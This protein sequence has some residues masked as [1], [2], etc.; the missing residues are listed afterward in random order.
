M[1]KLEKKLRMNLQFFS[2]E[3]PKDPDNKDGD[4]KDPDNDP[5][6][7]DNEPDD[8]GGDPDNNSDGKTF[9]QEDIDRIVR[10]RLDRERKKREDAVKKEREEAERKRLEENEE[11]K[12]L[13]DKL[14]EQLDEQKRTALETKKESLLA[15]AG[16]D[17]GQV[18][19][20]KKYLDGESEEELKAALDDLKA[21]IPPKKQY[22]DPSPGNGSKQPPKKTNLEEKGKS[23][24]QRLKAKGKIRGKK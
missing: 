4:T 24:Y 10:E 18:Q 1:K 15:T 22:G 11:Y 16:Y 20:Y 3:D 17:E 8:T 5:K 19:R 6:D 12:E 14:Q 7:P 9:T 13:A 2:E 21:D 23:A